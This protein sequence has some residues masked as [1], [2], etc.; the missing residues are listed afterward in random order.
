MALLRLVRICRSVHDQ[1]FVK[2]FAGLQKRALAEGI[3]Y[4]S[5]ISS[6]LHKYFEGRLTEKNA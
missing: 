5:L 2:G 4:Q 1:A 6:I 3:P